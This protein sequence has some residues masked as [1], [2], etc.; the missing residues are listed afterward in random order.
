MLP[1]IGA[2]GLVLIISLFYP[3]FACLLQLLRYFLFTSY[4]KRPSGGLVGRAF[5]WL[6]IGN[7]SSA[8]VEAT[9]CSNSS[10]TISKTVPKNTLVIY[11][12]SPCISNLLWVE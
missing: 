8:S 10:F 2:K 3:S 7:L 6:L 9:L 11:L 4:Q 12:E 1:T 5:T